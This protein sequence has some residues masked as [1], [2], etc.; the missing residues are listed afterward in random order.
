MI[1]I[2]SA[3]DDTWKIIDFGMTTA[4]TSQDRPTEYSRG[5][6]G[7]RPPE[8]LSDSPRY[9][10]NSDIWGLGCILYELVTGKTAFTGDWGVREFALCQHQ[11]YPDLRLPSEWMKEIVSDLVKKM[12]QVEA[13]QRPSTKTLREFLGF[14][15]D[16]GNV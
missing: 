6:S 13:S 1:V 4:G 7:Y 14:A 15:V 2:Y 8:L 16:P 3:K 9:S 12:L 5:M 10:R 11:I